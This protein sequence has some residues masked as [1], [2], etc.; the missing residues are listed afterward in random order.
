VALSHGCVRLRNSDLL[1]L[2]A[3][4]PVHCA[5]RIDEAACPDWAVAPLIKDQ[6]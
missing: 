5:V 2:F 4:V 1:E 3:R 6:L